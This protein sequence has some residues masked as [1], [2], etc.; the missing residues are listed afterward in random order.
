MSEK[1][2]RSEIQRKKARLCYL[3]EFVRENV[4]HTAQRFSGG[5]FATAADEFRRFAE[6]AD[7]IARLRS[8]ITQLTLD[9]ETSAP[10]QTEFP[11]AVLA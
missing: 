11:Q 8:E 9:L 6:H 7:E 10:L 5:F 2:I 3:T 4:P 1:Q